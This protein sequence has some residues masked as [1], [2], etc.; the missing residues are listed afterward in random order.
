MSEHDVFYASWGPQE[1][2]GEYIWYP[3]FYDIDT[4]LGVNNSG[5]PSWEY[6]DEP[7][8][9]GDFST[10]GSVLWNNFYTCFSNT[11]KETYLNLRKNNLTYEKLNGYYSYDPNYISYR[12]H[13]NKMHNSYVMR[14]HRPI[15]IINVDFL[16][17]R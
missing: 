9:Q 15:N 14:G 16:S 8:K 5:V 2:G 7:T 3:I 10:S 13:D 1:L 6:Y 12:G 11:I 17:K 4:Q